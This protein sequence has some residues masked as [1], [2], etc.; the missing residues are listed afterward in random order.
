MSKSDVT[1]DIQEGEAFELDESQLGRGGAAHPL[2]TTSRGPR[3]LHGCTDIVNR[4][5]YY[6]LGLQVNF[7]YWFHKDNPGS[8]EISRSDDGTISCGYCG[9]RIRGQATAWIHKLTIYKTAPPGA[10]D[11]RAVSSR[12]FLFDLS[13]TL[14]CSKCGY[15]WRK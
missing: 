15:I 14:E 2:V 3:T 9:G 4:S 5:R 13:G 8:V 11:V 10:R 1:L 6:K 7:Q 12:E